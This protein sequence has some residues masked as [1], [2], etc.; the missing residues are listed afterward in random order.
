MSIGY[1][2]WLVNHEMLLGLGLEEVSGVAG[3]V[4]HDKARGD[5]TENHHTCTLTGATIA[6]GSVASG[7]PYLAFTPATPDYLSCPVADTTDLDFTAGQDFSM[8]AWIYITNLADRCIMARGLAAGGGTDGWGF[9]VDNTGRVELATMQ[10]GATQAT[11]STVTIVINTWFLVG[12]CVD[13]SANSARTY[14][15]GRDKTDAPASHTAPLTSARDLRVGYRLDNDYPFS[16]YMAYPR[17][18]GR[19]IGADQMKTIWNVE[20]HWFGL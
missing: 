8:A 15:N 19:D 16:G 3:D 12:A 20:R 10:A 2:K 1:D 13:I 4:V 17:I 11:Y 6:W 18:W 14:I 5:L 9:I 7:F